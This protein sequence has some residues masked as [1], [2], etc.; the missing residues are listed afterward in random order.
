[1]LR[2]A[3]LLPN[4][5]T[6]GRERIV[7]DLVARA[8]AN[9]VE[10]VVIAYDPEL[11]GRRLTVDAPMHALER[12][13][14][15]AERLHRLL[16]GER[17]DLL[18]A[19]GH[20]AAALARQSAVPMVATLHVA[21]GAG[22][23]WAPAIVA[24][25]RRARAVSAVSADLA[26]RFRWLAGCPIEVVPPG[27]SIDRVAPRPEGGTFTVGIAARLHPVKRHRDAIAALRLLAARGVACRLRLAGQGGE[28]AALRAQSA[29]LD[30]HFDGDVADMGAWLARLDAF[31]LPS[32]HEGT[33]LALLEA[34]S[35]GLPCVAARVGGVP[36]A[37]GEAAILVPR[38]RPEEIA[39][40]L[41]RLARDRP[42]RLDLG[43]AAAERA[44]RFD[45]E[46][47]AAAYRALYDRAL[48]A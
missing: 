17:I 21:L 11:P 25:L 14:G 24:G 27:I 44:L 43:A 41:A 36:D 13:G 1:M 39:E 35:A 3:H 18:H 40:A 5:V 47:Q 15:F 30:V 10:P 37:V 22:W 12:G 45:A 8:G 29:G 19:Q 20:V 2:V 34:M 46:A 48:S 33:P 42:L 31:L 28:E 32:D 23:R 7:A 38:R 16:A 26:R 6:G 9:A 4:M